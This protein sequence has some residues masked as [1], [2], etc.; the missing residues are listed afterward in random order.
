[1]DPNQAIRWLSRAADNGL[2][3]AQAR[4]G[5]LLFNGTNLIPANPKR[6]Q[7]LLDAAVASDD[8]LAIIQVALCY[9]NGEGVP[10]DRPRAS[11]LLQRAAN[12]GSAEARE[13]QK[14]FFPN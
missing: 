12:L 9:L 14:T 8:P 7:Q 5:S 2:P 13:L 6:A 3:I 1:M 11:Q 10:M 4:L